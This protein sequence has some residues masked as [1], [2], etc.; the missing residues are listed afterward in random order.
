LYNA[1]ESAY[2]KKGNLGRKQ[3]KKKLIFKE[4]L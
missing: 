1:F 3:E 4:G 2:A